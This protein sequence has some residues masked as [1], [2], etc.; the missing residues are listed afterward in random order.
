[1]TSWLRYN[2]AKFVVSR[3]AFWN[4][5]RNF[6]FFC[7]V[8]Y[9]SEP[10]RKHMFTCDW[11]ISIHFVFFYVSRFTACDRLVSGNDQLVF[12][13]AFYDLS[14][15]CLLQ[16]Y[17][18]VCLLPLTKIPLII[19]ISFEGY[20]NTLPQRHNCNHHNTLSKVIQTQKIG[21]Y[22]TWFDNARPKYM[23][24]E[25]ITS[26]YFYRANSSGKSGTEI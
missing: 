11:G 18:N 17:S 1:M 10:L 23:H 6:S 14:Y 16:E 4:L 12:F 21:V 7:F 15:S 20:W 24:T 13:K 2:I 5:W 8:N 22:T 19:A 9:L 26:C 25:G 3:R